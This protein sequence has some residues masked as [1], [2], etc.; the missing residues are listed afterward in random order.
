MADETRTV[1][2]RLRVSKEGD[3]NAFKE[4][5]SDVRELGDAAQEASAPVRGVGDSFESMAGKITKG[6]AVA[7]SVGAILSSIAEGAK[8]LGEAYGGLSDE[9]A[10][11]VDGLSDLGSAVS[12]LDVL[13]TAAAL[14]RTLGSAWVD[15]TD[16]TKGTAVAN[17]EL[18]DSMKDQVERTRS[19]L[20]I[21]REFVAAQ[22]AKRESLGQTAEAL[23]RQATVEQQ[24]GD[25]SKATSEAVRQTVRAYEEM[26]EQ[27]PPALAAVAEQLGIGSE[28]SERF[29]AKLGVSKKALDDQAAALS[30]F[31][32][33]F[34]ESNSQLSDADFATIF[35]GQIQQILD[36]YDRLKQ[37]AP[38]AIQS[39][40]QAWGISTTA[41]EQA[42]TAQKAAVDS[43]VAE[44]TGAPARVAPSLKALG[45]ALSGALSQIDFSALNTEQLE[46]AKN[47]M[48]QFV[49]QSRAAGK[50]IPN[51]VA[52]QAAALG[53]LVGAM[54]VAGGGATSFAGSQSVARNALEQSSGKVKSLGD[55][56]ANLT[57]KA[58]S[59]AG[60][61]VAA[62]EQIKAGAVKAGEGSEP[63]GNLSQKFNEALAGFQAA[64]AAATRAGQEIKSGA[65]SAGQGTGGLNEAGAAAK[66]AGEG[67][68]EASAGAAGLGPA[69]AQGKT[70][71]A[72]L[73][74]ELAGLP[75][76]LDPIKAA[77]SAINALK[78]D[79]LKA[80]V[81]SV[82]TALNG[83]KA[84]A[85]AAKAAVAA[86]P[87]A[88]NGDASPAPSGTEPVTPEPSEPPQAPTGAN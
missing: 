17:R 48:Q 53:V 71:V 51:D 57:G 88:G 46:N 24:A 55:D 81:A 7:Q 19:V 12:R 16:A 42:K 14:G 76:V 79:G 23:T 3:Q 4:T 37:Q 22:E 77:F 54:E 15:L 45:E 26:G 80:E 33:S 5:A 72:N 6:I 63:V 74:T 62:G 31:V 83:M 61:S 66:S 10:D 8:R 35:K 58:G 73:K 43:I 40:A 1:E 86:I 75:A 30:S 36:G 60:A 82:T 28:A 47:V 21:Q 44:I 50:Q 18:L 34:R 11:V 78:F 64:G 2:A 27:V 25:V 69:T 29:A 49:D 68:K 20:Q 9:T 13:E 39:L 32:E 70:G 41:A 52:D 38:P 85:D 84:A 56:L 59:A 65:E 67:L 87:A